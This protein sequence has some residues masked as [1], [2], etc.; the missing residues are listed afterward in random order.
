MLIEFEKLNYKLLILFIFS[1]FDPLRKIISDKIKDNNFFQLFRFYLSYLLSF[2]F[3]LIIK[4]RSKDN[5]EKNFSINNDDNSINSS[6]EN[7]NIKKNSQIW[8]N[9]LDNVK[10]EKLKYKKTKNFLFTVELI[11]IWL[12]LNTFNIIFKSIYSGEGYSFIIY[13][14]KQSFGVFF[15]I[16]YFIILSRIILNNKIYKHHFISLIIILINLSLLIINYIKW[17]PDFTIQ[18][19][20]YY[21]IFSFLFC[22]YHVLGKKYLNLFDNSPY[23]IMFNIGLISIIIFLVYDIIVF[24]IVGNNNTNIHGVIMGFYNNLNLSFIYLFILDIIFN[25]LC[26]IGIWLTVYYFTPFHFIISESLAEYFY[27]AYDWIVLGRDYKIEDVIAY[28]IIYIINIIFFMVFN[29]IIILNF[30]GLSYNIRKKI[31]E[32]EAIDNIL[33]MSDEE[34]G[35]SKENYDSFNFSNLSTITDEVKFDN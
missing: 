19:I 25:F 29:E 14:G 32:R 17:F 2:V 7:N 16:I 35:D 26:N 31:E 30:C 1:V 18:I 5:H 33:A 9:P 13:I 24:L 3:I 27:Y 8:I 21:F 12:L 4:Y 10:K 22:L 28:M 23:Y 15:E 11:S 6:E 20:Y 34:N